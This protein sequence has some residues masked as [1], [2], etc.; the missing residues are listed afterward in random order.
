M[1]KKRTSLTPRE[2]KFCSV[3]IA[4]D[5]PMEAAKEAGYNCKDDQA[6]A[7]RGYEI[8]NREVVKAELERLKGQEQERASITMQEITENLKRLSTKAEET[9]QLNVAVKGNELLGKHLGYFEKDN[10]REFMHTVKSLKDASDDDLMQ[11]LNQ[12]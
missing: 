2:L 3:Y 12:E 11:I 5:S 4:T 1:A 10:K 9:G 7:R 6:F 8:A